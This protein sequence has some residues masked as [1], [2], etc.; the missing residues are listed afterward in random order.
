MP[1]MDWKVVLLYVLSCLLVLTLLLCGTLLYLSWHH[2]LFRRPSSKKG[3]DVQTVEP[4]QERSVGEK[5][6]TEAEMLPGKQNLPV[7]ISAESIPLWTK[8]QQLMREEEVWRD[9]GLSLN[10]LSAMLGSN[11]TRVGRLMQEMGYEGYKDFV[12]RYRV[13]AFLKLAD[14]G[15]V[16]SIQDAFFSVGYQSKMT[17]LR[18]FK[19]YVGMTPTEYLKREKVNGEMEGSHG[20]S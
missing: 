5:L 20:A 12:N 16:T 7:G 17:A 8:L 4:E 9:P 15:E 6:P 13:E 11:R 1:G 10:Q 19:E 14:A 18:H 2:E 3:T